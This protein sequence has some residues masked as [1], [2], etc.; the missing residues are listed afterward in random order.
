LVGFLVFL[1]FSFFIKI[2][3]SKDEKIERYNYDDEIP[4]FPPFF[5]KENVIDSQK[6]KI[7]SEG[8]YRICVYGATAKNGGKGGRQCAEHYF[9][10]DSEI[11]FYYE[12]QESGGEGGK[13]CGWFRGK[14][15]NG[16]GLSKAEHGNNFRIIG[17][18]GGGDSEKKI[19]KG[20]DY[21]KDGQGNKYGRSGLSNLGKNKNKG[22]NGESDGSFGI[23]CGGGGGNGY[24]GGTGGG[25]GNKKEVGGGGGGSNYCNAEKCFISKPNH[26]IYSGFEM[27]KKIKN[28]KNI[29]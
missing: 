18:G 15:F 2:F 4:L 10:K 21:N 17:G 13:G 23:Y 24:N 12:G 6:K 29:N 28:K 3:I 9:E 22:S 8:I 19:N 5:N 25:Y 14:G 1:V 20:G 26:N 11:T 7:E 27:Y 16:A